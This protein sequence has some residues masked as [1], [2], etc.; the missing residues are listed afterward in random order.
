MK[1]V[2]SGAVIQIACDQDD[3]GCEAREHAD[4]PLRESASAHVPEVR[5]G[6]ERRDAPTPRRRQ[7][8]QLHRNPRHPR[9]RRIQHAV[10]AGE[11]RS[12]EKYGSDV[13]L[14]P[15]EA[16]EPRGSKGDPRLARG[17]HEKAEKPEP[18]RRRG[19]IE[20]DR[21]LRVL[22]RQQRSRQK[23]DGKNRHGDREP[24][25]PRRIGRLPERDPGFVDE[26][27]QA[28]KQ[29]LKRRQKNQDARS[30]CQNP[31][32]LDEKRGPF[33]SEELVK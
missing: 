27:V 31:T 13:R 15:A 29:R 20:A 10:E 12:A 7:I 14:R 4:D 16:Q 19:V 32:K 24:R 22:A 3:I 17:K 26:P 30:H 28:E 8:R 9:A 1:C 2:H 33:D 6:D 25:N 11:N 18:D 21:E 23:R 5:V